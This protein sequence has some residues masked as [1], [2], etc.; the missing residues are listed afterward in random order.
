MRR[1]TSGVVFATVT[2]V[3]WGGQFVVGFVCAVGDRDTGSCPGELRGD[4]PT[5]AGSSAG[6]QSGLARELRGRDQF[7]F[8][9]GTPAASLTVRVRVLITEPSGRWRAYRY[10][11]RAVTSRHPAR[12][13]RLARLPPVA[14]LISPTA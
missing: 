11:A 12:N 9:A 1:T 8:C 5:D 3:V 4:R 2:A 13:T 14:S 10:V 7:P 6:H